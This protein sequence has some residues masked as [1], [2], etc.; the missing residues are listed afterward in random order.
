MRRHV[1]TGEKLVRSMGGVLKHVIPMVA[2]HHER[3]D[4]T[5]YKGLKGEDIPLGARI[6]AVADTYDA[7]VTDRAYRRGRTHV[8]AVK[9]IR[10]ASGSQFDRAS[11]RCSSNS[12]KSSRRRAREPARGV[13][14]QAAVR[15]AWRDFRAR[16]RSLYGTPRGASAAVSRAPDDCLDAISGSRRSRSRCVPEIR[17]SVRSAGADGAA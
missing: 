12:T 8:Q 15:E 3:W 5:G 17:A 7:I 9:I 14:T 1:D 13:A 10:D 16:P 11:S 6:I 4:G 2:F